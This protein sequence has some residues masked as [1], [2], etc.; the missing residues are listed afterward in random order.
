MTRLR[1]ALALTALLLAACSSRCFAGTG[2]SDS[3]G[4]IIADGW[5]PI[6][7]LT[8]PD[9]WSERRFRCRVG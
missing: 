2:G 9:E 1:I 8:G 5:Q 6:E 3:E 7:G 4:L